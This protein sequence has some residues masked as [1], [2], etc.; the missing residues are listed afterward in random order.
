MLDGRRIAR[1]V[2]VGRFELSQGV[3]LDRDLGAVDAVSKSG[4][5]ADTYRFYQI[6][7]WQAGEL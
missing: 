5:Y 6:L 4:K 7:T 1:E 2:A 3:E